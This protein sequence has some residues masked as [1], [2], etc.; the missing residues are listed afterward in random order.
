MFDL[1]IYEIINILGLGLGML[2]GMIAQKNQF[3]FSGSIKDYI[4][5]KSTRRGA[6]VGVYQ[7]GSYIRPLFYRIDYIVTT[8]YLPYHF[9]VNACPTRDNVLISLDVLPGS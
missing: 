9:S 3:C 1:E 6:S 8:H 4:L 5:L 2:F 7:P